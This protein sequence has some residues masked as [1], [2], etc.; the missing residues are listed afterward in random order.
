MNNISSIKNCFGCGVC[1]IACPKK[2][3]DLRLN[4]KGFYEPFLFDESKCID[5]GLCLSVCSFKHDD[6]ALKDPQLKSYGAWSKDPKVRRKCSSG[7]V[8]FEIGKTLL[9]DGYKVCGVKYNI[10]A[11]RAEH[12]IASNLV[13]L[14]SSVGSKYLQ[15]YTIPG[16]LNINKKEKYLV[17]GTPCQIDSFRRFIQKF[18]CEDNFLLLDFFCHGVPSM[19]LW[20][21]YL[22]NCQKKVG[23]ITYVSWR[24]KFKYGWHDSWLM[25]ID[26]ENTSKKLNSP[27]SYES[28]IK[29]RSTFIQSRKSQGDFFYEAF[30]NNLC[31]NKPCYD[32]C[33]FKYSRSSADIRVGD[34]WGKTYVN[35]ELGVSSVV[36]FTAKGDD[37]LQKTNCTLEQYNFE[38]LCNSQMKENAERP[39]F[40]DIYNYILLKTSSFCML[41]LLNKLTSF[42]VQSKRRLLNPKQTLIKLYQKIS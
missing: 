15:S 6:T 31:L 38:T 16:F 13:E 35:D 12:Y 9:N 26:G 20:K 33:R 28:L 24:N 36:A 3:I 29:E 8:A 34:A 4:K 27:D 21:I 37:C 14:I 32:N 25:G 22:E 2:I 1:A 11:N 40:Y 30:L 17:T 42:W 7:G 41:M 18:H 10:D 5:C 39:M 19:L 23:K